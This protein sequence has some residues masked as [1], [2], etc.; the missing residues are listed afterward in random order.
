MTFLDTNIFLRFLTRDDE[1]KADACRELFRR[2]DVG[3]E[4]ATTSESVIAEVVYVLSARTGAGYRLTPTD[5]AGRLKPLIGVDGL[6]LPHKRR[7]RRALDVF[8]AHPFLDFED[9]LSVAHIEDQKLDDLTSYDADFDK[10][11]GITRKE[12]SL[13]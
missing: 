10:V 4:Q 2:L 8:A 7:Y 1:K 11:P 13:P 3:E 12:P 5:I 6:K 9:A